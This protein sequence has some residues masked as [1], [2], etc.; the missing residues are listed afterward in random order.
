VGL[1]RIELG[2]QTEHLITFSIEPKLDRYSDT[3]A[4]ALYDELIVRLGALPG[5]VL[6][7]AARVPAIAGS[8][9]SGSVT[10]EGFTPPDGDASESSFNVVGP[11]YFRTMGIPLV[12]G[13]ELTRGDDTG[14]SKVAVVNEAFV[15]HFLPGRDPLGRRFGWGLGRGVKLDIEIVGVVRDAKY[16]SLRESPSP[17]HYV[18]YRQALQQS[19]LHFY[20]RTSADSGAV[21]PLIRRV[22]A[23]LAPNLPVRDLK[24]MR[25]QIGENVGAERLLS[26]L[27]GSFAGLATLLAAIGLS[28]WPPCSRRSGCTA[29]WPTTWPDGPVRSGFGWPWAPVLRRCVASWSGRSRSRLRSAPLPA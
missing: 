10:V 1:T 6:T 5:V 18:G 29:C 3:H 14:G 17:V 25:Q 21:A 24:T 19:G 11:D 8:V 2:M 28:A 20:V 27:T 16:S 23:T 7:S 9:S 26:V 15:R 4:R 13:R 12:V 22:V